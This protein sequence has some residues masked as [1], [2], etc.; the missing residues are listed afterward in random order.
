VGEPLAGLLPWLLLQR[1][2]PVLV[3]E[4]A[5]GER[6]RLPEFTSGEVPLLV[7][8]GPEG[9]A[10]LRGQR[11]PSWTVPVPDAEERTA[12]WREHGADADQAWQ[13]GAAYRHSSARIEELVRLTSQAA[14]AGAGAVVSAAG[15]ARTARRSGHGALGSLA[16]L[17]S[18][19]IDAGA[20]VVPEALRQELRGLADRCRAREGLADGLGVSARTRYRPGVRALMVGASGT[21]KTLACSWL[22][23]QLG[24]PLYRVDLASVTSKYIGETEKNLGDLFA[25]AESAEV[26]ILFDEADALFGKRTEVK[27]ANDRYANQQTN[28]LLQRIESYDGI[29]VLTSNSRSRFDSAFTRRLDAILEFPL[30]SPVERRDLWLAHLGVAHDLSVTDLN[31]LAALCDLAGGH[32]RNAALVAA[33]SA[34]NECRNI[35]M[36][37][38]LRGIAAEYGKLGRQVPN[39]LSERQ[40]GV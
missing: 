18:D 14:D 26:M 27:D 8:A 34:R 28:Y 12:L 39:G 21:G 20:L 23:T 5:P 3:T 33:V 40:G 10:D 7:M 37:D 13:L 2:M 31:R 17:V 11:P 32:I 16:D 38:V 19:D 36:K 35:G 25:R 22:A 4:M 1:A 9:S 30:P 15:V 29:V 6:L 24:M